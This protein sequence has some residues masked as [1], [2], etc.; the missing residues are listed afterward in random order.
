MAVSDSSASDAQFSG[1]IPVLYE[2]L[3]VPM[4]FAEPA[5]RTARRVGEACP[6]TLLETAAGT[7]VLTRALAGM[8]LETDIV[9]TDLNQPMLDVAERRQNGA[10]RVRW[11]QADALDLPF[12]DE[13]FDAVVCQ[14]GAMFFPDRVQGFTE[15]LRVL[16]PGRP[17]F[18]TVWDRVERNELA[19]A[20]VDALRAQPHTS[21]FDFLER[22]PHGYADQDRIRMDLERAGL[23]VVS[24]TSARGTCT[25]TA[26]DAALA[27]CQGTPIRHEIEA[28][29]HLD[30]VGA[31]AAVTAAL[32][33]RYGTGTFSVPTGWLEIRAHA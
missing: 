20:V 30:L 17:L 12:A 6:A 2:R 31:T 27:Y 29:E 11:Q 25:T 32:T 26:D 8:C 10:D 4:I 1:S 15:A 22:K 21:A 7:G 3:L 14:F 33:E 18:L 5:Q 23:P 13:M 28:D 16:R 24:I 19:G 9:A